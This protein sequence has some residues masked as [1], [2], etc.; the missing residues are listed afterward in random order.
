MP[1]NWR[2]ATYWVLPATFSGASA[3]GMRS[4]IPRTSRDV[5]ITVAMGLALLVRP[6]TGRGRLHDRRDHLGVAR[7]AAEVAGDPQADLL[8]CRGRTGLQQR[9]GGHDH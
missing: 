2:S 3:R 6:G 9:A 7:A 8:L 5:F 4:P 1:G